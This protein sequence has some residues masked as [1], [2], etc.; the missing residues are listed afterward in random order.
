[1]T[2]SQR[3]SILRLLGESATLRSKI[4]QADT[5]L[6]GIERERNRLNRELPALKAELDRLREE[7]SIAPLRTQELIARQS[8]RIV[9]A[10]LESDRLNREEAKTKA[11]REASAIRMVACEE[12][13]AAL[14]SSASPSYTSNPASSGR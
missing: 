4:A 5:Y 13:R 11:L 12:E 3:F 1:M 9:V 10:G 2:D 8:S 6:A 7:D 14:E